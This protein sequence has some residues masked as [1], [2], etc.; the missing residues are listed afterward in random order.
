[1]TEQKKLNRRDAI[2]LIGAAAGASVLANIPAKWSK[3]SFVSGVLPAHAQTS[4]C[5]P[6]TSSMLVEFIEV[7]GTEIGVGWGSN[8]PN[9]YDSLIEIT[10]EYLKSGFTIFFPCFDGCAGF[11]FGMSDNATATVRVTLNG[12]VIAEWV[13]ISGTSHGVGFNGATGEYAID[14]EILLGCD[15]G[16]ESF[17]YS[18]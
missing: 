5:G 18:W 4:G 8:D 1:M 7:N 12:N 2:K 6:G 13:D 15:L 16:K 14:N 3:P 11:G 10:G 17:K 9:N